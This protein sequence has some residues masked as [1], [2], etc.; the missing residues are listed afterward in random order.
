MN[1]KDRRL[2]EREARRKDGKQRQMFAL[3]GNTK[4]RQ[5]PNEVLSDEQSADDDGTGGH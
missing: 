4:G 1:R 2:A 3:G 5:R